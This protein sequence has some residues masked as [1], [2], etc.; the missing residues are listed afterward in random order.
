MVKARL[1]V[2]GGEPAI[3]QAARCR[4]HS[5][6]AAG[7]LL[8]NTAC[9]LCTRLDLSCSCERGQCCKAKSRAGKVQAL[10]S[11]SLFLSSMWGT[12][13]GGFP[14]TSKAADLISAAP[15]T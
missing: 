12:R 5:D 15:G 1:L 6:P 8:I 3:P 14:V 7:P 10:I 2:I 11:H 9:G 13:V 4:L